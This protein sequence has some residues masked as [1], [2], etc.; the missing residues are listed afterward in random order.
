MNSNFGEKYPGMHEKM[1]KT[2]SYC[3]DVW[4]ETFPQNQAKAKKKLDQRKERA[5]LAKELEEKMSKMT[6][7]ELDAYMESIPE[8]KRGALVVTEGGQELEQEEVQGIFK[9]VRSKLGDKVKNTKIAKDFYEE[10]G[11]TIENAKKEYAEFKASAR[12]QLDASHNPMIR[13]TAMAYDKIRDDTGQAKAITAMRKYDPEFVFE[14]LHFEV[15]EVF[16]EFY[17]NYLDGNKEYI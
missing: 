17:V 14:D 10:Q 13:G 11:E 12:E 16:R 7:E 2:F 15:D 9:R 4:Q 1:S 5:R 8:W 3:S 6:P